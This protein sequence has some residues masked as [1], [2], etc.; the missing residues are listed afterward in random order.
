MIQSTLAKKLNN[1]HVGW[2][3]GNVIQQLTGGGGN[4]LLGCRGMVDAKTGYAVDL[5]WG[6]KSEARLQTTQQITEK[7][8][9]LMSANY[10]PEQGLGLTF[11]SIQS[12]S[13]LAQGTA[14]VVMGPPEESGVQ[15]ALNQRT[16]KTSISTKVQVKNS[17]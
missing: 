7:N 17:R 16:N 4:L 13:D 1:Q 9:G 11:S 3:G 5:Q 12:F 14:S 2:I 15:L 8:Q 6:S 10:T